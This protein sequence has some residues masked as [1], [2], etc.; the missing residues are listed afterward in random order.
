MKRSFMLLALTTVISTGAY[1]QNTATETQRDA[2]Q[3]ERIE[4][5]LKSGQLSSKEAGSLERDEQRVDRTE[6][7]DMKNGA[8][9][10][11]EKAQIQREQNHVSTDVYRD[12]HNAVTGNPDSASSQRMQSDVQRNANQQ[13][14]IN[15]GISS[16]QLSNH[17]AG[18]LERGQAHIDRAEANSATNGHVGAREQAR[19][20][21][22]ENYQSGRVYRKKHNDTV[23]S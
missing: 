22:K 13:E 4:Q 21:G 12:K 7:H 6:A 15:Q 23:R 3:Q 18:S 9:S 8:L 17:E 16:G 10:S 5:G 1:A 14:R 19:I 20:Q 2:N 11:Q